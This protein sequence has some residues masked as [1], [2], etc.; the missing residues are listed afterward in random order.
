MPLFYSSR[1]VLIFNMNSAGLILLLLI[2]FTGAAARSS[3]GGRGGGSRPSGGGSKPSSGYKPPSGPRPS[4]G[5]KPS[6][7]TTVSSRNTNPTFKPVTPTGAPTLKSGGGGYS[8]GA[9]AAAAA[10]GGATVAV[11]AGTFFYGGRYSSPSCRGMY[12][13]SSS[14][15]PRGRSSTDHECPAQIPLCPIPEDVRERWYVG[16]HPS[17]EVLA[18]ASTC[19]VSADLSLLA[20]ADADLTLDGCLARVI[21]DGACATSRF[22]LDE[23]SGKCG[24]CAAGASPTP[25]KDGDGDGDGFTS[26]VY[27]FS[28]TSPF[29][30][31]GPPTHCISGATLHWPE[32]MNGT[33]A[34]DNDASGNTANSIGYADRTMS[35]E[36]GSCDE[37]GAPGTSYL[38]WSGPYAVSPSLGNDGVALSSDDGT[39]PTYDPVDTCICNASG[40]DCDSYSSFS[41]GTTVPALP[42]SKAVLVMVIASALGLL[43]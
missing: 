40:V 6:R 29:E 12:R 24:C 23:V 18:D 21:L 42:G 3:G 43:L 34:A 36:C 2:A 32:S 15:C 33:T 4:S 13:Y 5:S 7:P 20:P 39:A 9:K 30:E 16:P 41:A 26:A 14:S 27:S 38:D 35:C 37:C 31:H 10:A 22:T 28:Y 25:L 11:P 8:T 17:V 19:S 1:S